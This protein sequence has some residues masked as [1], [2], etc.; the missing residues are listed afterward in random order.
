M[1]RWMLIG[2]QVKLKNAS[3]RLSRAPLSE[4]AETK[5]GTPS[6]STSSRLPGDIMKVSQALAMNMIA[7]PTRFSM[8]PR[9][10]CI[11]GPNL[12]QP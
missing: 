11:F 8:K 2:I 3:R 9:N 10:R 4:T 12:P 1:I 6:P 7:V 5:S